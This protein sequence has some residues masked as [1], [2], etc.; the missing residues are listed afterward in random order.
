MNNSLAM[1]AGE[2]LVNIIS[3]KIGFLDLCKISRRDIDSMGRL[4]NKKL[5]LRLFL[6]YILILA[7]PI[8]TIGYAMSGWF[9][10]TLEAQRIESS[11]AIV[12][13]ARDNLDFQLMNLNDVI[14]QISRNT[15]V[16][17]LAQTEDIDRVNRN[18]LIRDG[19]RELNKYS[20][21]DKFGSDIWVYFKNHDLV[22]SRSRYYSSDKFYGEVINYED[23]TYEEWLTDI[24]DMGRTTVWT[25]K[26]VRKSSK[27]PEKKIIT[28]IDTKSLN[29]VVFIILIDEAKLLGLFGADKINSGSIFGIIDERDQAMALSTRSKLYLKDNYL[30]GIGRE[31][32]SFIFS[33]EDKKYI[34]AFD[35]SHILDWNLF[36][37][38][39]KEALMGEI[40]WIESLLK[41]I[42]VVCIIIGGILA[43]IMSSKNY[44]PVMEILKLM[45]LYDESVDFGSSKHEYDLIKDAMGDIYKRGQELEERL[46]RQQPILRAHILERLIMDNTYI[47]QSEILD[48]TK[49]YGL[50]FNLD[51]FLVAVVN[52]DDAGDFGNIKIETTRGL[53]FF[54][55]SNIGNEIL[56]RR[57]I[58]YS[59]ERDDKIVFIV[60]YDKNSEEPNYPLLDLFTDIKDYIGSKMGIFISIGV[61]RGYDSIYELSKSFNN[62]VTVCNLGLMNGA[63][64]ITYYDDALLYPKSF[65]YP[66][67]REIKLINSVKAGDIV[68]AEEILEVIY[69]ANF[70]AGNLSRQME[71]LV[72]NNM[73]ST[74]F[75]TVDDVQLLVDRAFDRQ[76]EELLLMAN[77]VS[78][79]GLFL[80]IKSLFL[81]ICEHMAGLKDSNNIKLKNDIVEYIQDNYADKSLALIRIA[82]EFNIS[83][84]YLSKFFKEQTG[85]NL[86]EY[87]NRIRVD[88]GKRLLE[89]TDMTVQSIALRVGYN[90]A[91]TFIRVFKKYENITPGQYRES[92]ELLARES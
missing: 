8:V 70:G 50:D 61:G 64:R 34:T 32:G 60:N 59:I 38:L 35:S 16:R 58:S 49:F 11:K 37:T 83:V 29:N 66:P 22:L 54:A 65:Y 90:S 39:E 44:R 56:E 46:E 26:P 85:T 5:F 6:S 42:M 40:S 72:L 53:A 31:A 62:A 73:M 28:H 81:E 69:E 20:I 63:D 68:A 48:A 71:R 24:D 21:H 52:I 79:E 88:E 33:D 51:T 2:L 14:F 80:N 67:E 77:T 87:L 1:K 13:Q 3:G 84:P 76:L 18:F 91:N 19:M 27:K 41:L 75:K 43:Y 45:D 82:D 9:F 78:P 23:I 7:L 92:Q 25:S 74:L 86:N 12:Y 57:A 17:K 89:T 30:E 4:K 15:K 55:I 10:S 47:E 36:Y